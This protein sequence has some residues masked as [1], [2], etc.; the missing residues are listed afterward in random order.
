MDCTAKT[1]KNYAII[2]VNEVN[3][4]R[5]LSENRLGNRAVADWLQEQHKKPVCPTEIIYNNNPI[6]EAFKKQLKIHLFTSIPYSMFY[7]CFKITIF[8]SVKRCWQ[9]ILKRR[10]INPLLL[11]LLLLLLIQFS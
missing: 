10:Y 8:A 7:K 2:Y 11:V 1:N 5:D 3:R 6:P 4:P 9:F